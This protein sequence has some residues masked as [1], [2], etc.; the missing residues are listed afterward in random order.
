MTKLDRSSVHPLSLI[1][2]L[3]MD[4]PLNRC[5]VHICSN[6]TWHVCSVHG[7]GNMGCVAPGIQLIKSA[8][9][10]PFFISGTLICDEFFYYLWQNS[11]V[12]TLLIWK[13]PHQK[14]LRLKKTENNHLC[15]GGPIIRPGFSSVS[16][17]MVNWLTRTNGIGLPVVAFCLR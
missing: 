5:C 13:L 1:I 12:S 3:S 11:V 9:L 2:R 17:Y 16:L 4:F 15:L 8:N 10:R 7:D 14:K 6:V